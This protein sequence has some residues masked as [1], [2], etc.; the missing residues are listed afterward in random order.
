MAHVLLYVMSNLAHDLRLAIRTLLKRPGF[1]AVT[2]LTLALGIGANSAI[3]SVVNAV[4]LEPLPY[5]E[6]E[7]LVN[8]WT[9]L[10]EAG[11]SRFP[12]SEVEFLDY[13]AETDLF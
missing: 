3:F 11:R 2:L 6:P 13:R 7:A 9:Q 4:L 1:A 10:P 5:E 8:V 12:S